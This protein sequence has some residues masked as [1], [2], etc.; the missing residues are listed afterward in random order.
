M[1]VVRF[2]AVYDLTESPSVL[3]SPPG[4]TRGS[5]GC[6]PAG[7]AGFTKLAREARGSGDDDKESDLT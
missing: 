4:F 7:V 2:S 5:V 6:W 1:T 3:S